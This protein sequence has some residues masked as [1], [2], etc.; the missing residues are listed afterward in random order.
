MAKSF[1]RKPKPT[2]SSTIFTMKEKVLADSGVIFAKTTAAPVTPPKQK[3]FGNLKKYTP[4]A[5]I[6]VLSVIIRKLRT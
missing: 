1:P 4:I 6:N 5:I 3:L 2:K